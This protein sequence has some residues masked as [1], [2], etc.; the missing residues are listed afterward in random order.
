MGMALLLQESPSESTLLA[1]ASIDLTAK[2]WKVSKKEVV[3][4]ED[5]RE[6]KYLFSVEEAAQLQGHVIGLSSVAFHPQGFHPQGNFVVT[7]SFDHM[8]Q[9][10]DVKNGLEVLLQDGH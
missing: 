6:D 10:W 3:H 4:L 2:P 5:D 1:T 8:W 7:M 9:L